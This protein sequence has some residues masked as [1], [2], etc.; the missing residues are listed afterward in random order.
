MRT[1]FS[2]S[3]NIVDLISEGNRH[4]YYIT[5]LNTFYRYT[6][7]MYTLKKLYTFR[8]IDRLLDYYNSYYYIHQLKH[9]PHICSLLIT[10][11]I[12]IPSNI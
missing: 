4:P 5:T 2:I 7:N 6:Y 3:I 1:K 9:I 11:N 10:S 8:Y 12:K